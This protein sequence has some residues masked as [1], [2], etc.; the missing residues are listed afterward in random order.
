MNTIP[1]DH[2]T[3]ENCAADIWKRITREEKK[4]CSWVCGYRA[5]SSFYHK[6]A[7]TAHDT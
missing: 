3:L 5:N 7:D 1:E 2:S 6:T 4:G